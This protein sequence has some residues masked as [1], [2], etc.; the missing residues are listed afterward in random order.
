MT[1]GID[2]EQGLGSER[3]DGRRRRSQRSRAR[4]LEA[5]ADLLDAGDSDLTIER[6]AAHAGTSVSTVV[7]NMRDQ[8]GLAAAMNE[9]AQARVIKHLE[10][11]PFEGSTEERVTDLVRRM[12]GM[13]ETVV[14]LLRSMHRFRQDER[15]AVERQRIDGVNRAY[16]DSAL[17]PELA[18]GPP[19]LAD[20]LH[21]VVSTSAWSHL[22]RNQG[23]DQER[24]AATMRTT[25]LRVLGK[26]W[27]TPTS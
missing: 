1:R 17:A 7:R 24:A 15:L 25:V 18:E 4:I 2:V 11:G 26:D 16:V 6:V 20:V 12:A 21:S 23:F 13:F 14:P 22:R 3:E 9:I 10:G 5:I 19:E 8:E 27:P